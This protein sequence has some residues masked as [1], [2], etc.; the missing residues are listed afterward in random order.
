M[1][2]MIKMIDVSELYRLGAFDGTKIQTVIQPAV[3]KMLVPEEPNIKLY[4]QNDEA[5]PRLLALNARGAN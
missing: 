1:S 5:N 2:N 4:V 3:A